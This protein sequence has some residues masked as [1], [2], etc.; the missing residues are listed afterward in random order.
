MALDSD[1]ELLND[2]LTEAGE[3]LEL[4]NEQLVDLEHRPDDHE[5][6]N[7]VFRGFHTIKGGAGFL[8]LDAVVE[9]CH[10]AEDVFNL[11]RNGVRHVDAEL[12]DVILPVLDVV[13][14][15]FENMR[16]DVEPEHASPELLAALDI[17]ARP[18]PTR[19]QPEIDAAGSDAG[20]AVDREY[21]QLLAAAQ[22]PDEEVSDA[23]PASAA[24]S[25]TPVDDEITED[26]FDALLDKL[27][28]QK[29]LP[30]TAK[31]SS[32][33][34]SD[35]ITEQEFDELL[36][37][38]HGPG[39]APGA[40]AGK[41]GSPAVTSEDITE[42]EFDELLDALH[43]AGGAPGAASAGSKTPQATISSDEISESEFDA[44]LDKLHGTK[45]I[46][47]SSTATAA[48]KT[49]TARSRPDK[50]PTIAKQPGTTMPGRETTTAQAETSI[51]VDTRRLD[52]I[53][54]LVGEL[55]L[56]RNRIATLETSQ[57]D[58]VT[59]KVVAN[60]DVVTSDLHA[61]VMK[62]RMQPV[63]KVFGRFPRVVRDLSRT[64]KKEVELELVGEETDLDKNLVDALADP[65]VHLVRNAVDHG[66]EAPEV[67]QAAGK[68]RTGKIVLSAR[69]EGDHILLE[70]KD[71]G[72]GMDAEKLR[73]MVV[74]KGLLD[75]A[76]AQ[77]LDH[78][79]CFNLIFMPGFSTKENISDVSGRGV[80][81]DVVKSRI[82]QLNGLVDI[83]SEVGVGTSLTIRVPLT[84]AIMPTLMIC[85][86][87]QIF[88][89][90]LVNV[91]EIITM[92]LRH[93]NKV[94]G[95][96]VI[97]IRER[98]LPVFYLAHWLL[99]HGSTGGF[100]DSGHV[101][102]VNIG[103]QQ[104]GLVVD[105]LIGQEEVVIKPLGCMLQN[106]RGLAGA[107]IT[108]NGKLALILDLQE[109]MTACVGAG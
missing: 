5:L 62:T 20:D 2:F 51:R 32:A 54:N 49:A 71:D 52:Q 16:A 14:A 40:T 94:D 107:T 79:E 68:P 8:Q 80:G 38:L 70:I 19:Q 61:A 6:L 95:Q 85:L 33:T 1:R 22:T 74:A 59:A 65:L 41:G 104:V 105:H 43:G 82:N 83:D 10:R 78:K 109:L 9:V 28:G 46:P 36:D 63:K 75:E 89:L 92:D 45:G 18:P 58:E 64:L 84:L 55:V 23:A 96:T 47:G 56:V 13:N 57:V 26:E 24:A 25:V 39:A 98:V 99:V 77:R 44:L 87:Q 101:V 34:G 30:G 15:Q 48:A 17:L 53:M 93:T 12:M 4:L 21:E 100:P 60:L 37:S 103:S 3:I 86:G 27:H 91:N 97:M 35:N 106:T 81:M 108:G 29:G 73:T 90:P 42:A 11:L 31:L 50:A 69:Q 7:A 88:A 67:R 66:I 76:S 72:A 102:V